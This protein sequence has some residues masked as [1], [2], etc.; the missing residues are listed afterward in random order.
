MYQLKNILNGYLEK[1]L[2]SRFIYNTVYLLFTPFIIIYLFLRSRRAPEYRKRI[3]ERFA[4]FTQPK[5]PIDILIHAVSLGEVNAISPLIIEIKKKYPHAHIA[6]TTTTPTGSNLLRQKFADSIFHTYMPYDI[7]FLIKRFLR[8]IKPK[9]LIIVETEL[10]P[11]LLFICKKKKIPIMLAN[12]RLSEQ[13]ADKYHKLGSFMQKM[14]ACIS[15]LAVQTKEES[16][17]FIKLGMNEQNIRITGSVKFDIVI[18]REIIDKAILLRQSFKKKKNIW[19]AASTHEGEEEIVLKAFMEAKKVISNLLLILVPRHPERFV[20]VTNLCRQH[21][22]SVALRS[23]N[24]NFEE[25]DIYLGDTLGEL[26][27][28]YGAADLVFLGGSLIQRGGHNLLEP[29]ALGLPIITGPHMFNFKEIAKL[30]LSNKGLV[31]IQDGHSLGETVIGLLQNGTLRNEIGSNAKRV[32]ENNRG[33]LAKHLDILQSL[34]NLGE[35]E[36]TA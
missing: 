36:V 8:K 26:V 35:G 33:A 23:K 18:P 34:I 30:L 21:Q 9:L 1:K 31:Q 2:I 11:N 4:Y 19:I 32:L 15:I 6:V 29:A 12:A 7:S 25:M 22:F 10:W 20:N 24:E 17:R 28:L 3:G 27:L 16:Q 5:A 13:S 14:L